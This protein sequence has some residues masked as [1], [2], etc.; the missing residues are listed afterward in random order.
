MQRKYSKGGGW[1]KESDRHR[2]ARMGVKTG[3][4]LAS[5]GVR[6]SKNIGGIDYSKKAFDGIKDNKIYDK[7]SKEW[8]DREGL[9][10][11]ISRDT[12]IEPKENLFS[13]EEL[14]DLQFEEDFEDALYDKLEK[15][16][17]KKLL[18]FYKNNRFK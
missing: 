17:T 4:K 16:D 18:L 2:L 13:E 3:K 10:E 11:L 14:E 6:L 9:M 7:K 1:F 5:A 8:Y 12:Y 15:W